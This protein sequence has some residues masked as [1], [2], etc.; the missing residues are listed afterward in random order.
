M[1]CRFIRNLHVQ[2]WDVN[3]DVSK[4]GFKDVS[5]DGSKDVSK[6]GSTDEFE[7]D[8]LLG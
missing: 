7:D 6:D 3:Q 2:K 4:D 1:F 5:K 8:S